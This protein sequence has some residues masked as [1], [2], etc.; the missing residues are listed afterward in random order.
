[1]LPT[2]ETGS[3]LENADNIARAT[4]SKLKR[5]KQEH[6]SSKSRGEWQGAIVHKHIAVIANG[7]KT[8]QHRS[9]IHRRSC[10]VKGFKA[11]REGEQFKK[12][13]SNLISRHKSI[14]MQRQGLFMLTRD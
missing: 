3:S 12:L 13:K 14:G 7:L 8:L 9:K 10:D 5:I 4:C 6:S 11:R 1:M 2:N